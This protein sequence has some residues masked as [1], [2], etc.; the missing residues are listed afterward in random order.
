[1][2]PATCHPERKHYARGKCR[3]CFD[4]GR[5]EARREEIRA[6]HRKW[7][8]KRR[9]ANIAKGLNSRGEPR[10]VQGYVKK[11]EKRERID[12]D[13]KPWEQEDER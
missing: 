13:A 8:R 6:Y 5:R 11:G 1:M 3:R 7:S 10:C 2:K 4:A 9:R 12:T